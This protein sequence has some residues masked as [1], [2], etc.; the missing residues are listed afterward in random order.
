MNQLPLPRLLG[1][2]GRYLI[3]LTL[4]LL[5]ASRSLAAPCDVIKA[6]P[7]VWMN[8][9]VNALVSSARS[10]YERDSAE[11]AYGRAIDATVKL[12][13]KCRLVQDAQFSTEYPE[14][15]GF[16]ATLSLG[17]KPD[18]ELGFN[19]PDKIYF[20]QTRQYVEIPDFLL[21]PAFLRAVSRSE[22]LPE[23]KTMLRQLNTRRP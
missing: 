23:A 20:E 7:D 14:F 16:I 2:T 1:I 22:T 10:F 15:I 11:S 13:D 5:T 12:M 6:R 3:I 8:R 4:L 18:H 9:T 19:V 21:T 17:R